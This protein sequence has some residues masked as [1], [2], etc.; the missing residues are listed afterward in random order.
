MLREFYVGTVGLNGRRSHSSPWWGQILPG[1]GCGAELGVSALPQ[2][3]A[4]PVGRGHSTVPVL[5]AP[6]PHRA[7]AAPSPSD[8]R[9]ETDMQRNADLSRGDEKNSNYISEQYLF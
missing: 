6:C 8:P 2:L 4:V 7:V 1:P 3:Q 5:G 9:S